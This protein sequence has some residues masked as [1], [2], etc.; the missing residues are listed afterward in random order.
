MTITVQMMQVNQGA[1][2][3]VDNTG[4]CPP[5]IAP[6]AFTTM[7][8]EEHLKQHTYHYQR[9]NKP[10]LGNR[11]VVTAAWM[12]QLMKR[13]LEKPD[14]PLAYQRQPLEDSADALFR[15]GSDGL[16]VRAWKAYQ[17]DKATFKESQLPGYEETEDE[18]KEEEV[19]TASGY[20]RNERLS[21]EQDDQ[22][23]NGEDQDG[24][25]EDSDYE[26]D[27][28]KKGEAQRGYTQ[29]DRV[30]QVL[31][32]DRDSGNAKSKVGVK[33]AVPLVTL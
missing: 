26:D 21:G 9:E 20:E 31:E 27:G 17:Y 33:I 8:I 25:K 6:R 4:E 24:Y 3:L 28:A 1:L 12:R 22:A 10:G 30:L 14:R 5:D 23:S 19:A 7:M 32:D 11:Q 18:E 29:Q 13:L 2:F 15:L 16:A